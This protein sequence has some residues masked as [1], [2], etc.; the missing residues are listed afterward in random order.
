MKKWSH[1]YAKCQN[2]GSERFPHKGRG[3]CKRCYPLVKRMEK[4]DS[5]DLSNPQSLKGYPV[6]ALTYRNENYKRKLFI[7]LKYGCKAQIKERLDFLRHREAKLTGQVQVDGL[8]LEMSLARIASKCRKIKDYR[9]LFFGCAGSIDAHFD[10][11]QKRYLFSLLNRIEENIPWSGI[12]W[13]KIFLS[14]RYI[15]N[16]PSLLKQECTMEDENPEDYKEKSY[17]KKRTKE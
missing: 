15:D 7:E 3:Y 17:K 14:K 5:W 13:Q 9:R 12:N 6:M 11:E 16:M 2:C 8:T 10:A 4:I 1:E